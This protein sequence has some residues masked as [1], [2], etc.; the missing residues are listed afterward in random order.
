MAQDFY[1]VAEMADL[2]R[3]RPGTI[4]NRVS[5]GDPSVP[6]SAVIGRRRLFPLH[7]YEV[8]KQGLLER[9]MD[10]PTSPAA[11]RSDEWSPRILQ[12]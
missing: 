2:L 5:R 11:D 9:G 8:W 10:R 7:A 12:R 3:V 1:T 6:P 4:R